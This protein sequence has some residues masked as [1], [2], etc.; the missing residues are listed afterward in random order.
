MR[1][2]GVRRISGCMWQL[3]RLCEQAR[4]KRIDLG[5]RYGDPIEQHLKH[6]RVVIVQK[7]QSSREV[8]G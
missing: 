1:F 8:E 4:L 7:V 6:L 5:V 2:S 3:I